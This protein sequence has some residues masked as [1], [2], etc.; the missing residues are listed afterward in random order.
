MQF[1]KAQRQQAKLRIGISAP[2]GFGKTKSSL[3]LA[4]GLCE[5]WEKIAVIDTEN[6]SADL[7]SHLGPYNVVSLDEPFS[8]EAFIKAI[9]LCEGEGMEVIIVDS[10]SA[11]WS[12]TGGCL[13]IKDAMGGAYQDWKHVTPRH[14]ALMAKIRR[15]TAHII[16][17]TR[18]KADYV[19]QLNDKGK[20]AP[21]KLG[22]KEDQRENYEYELDVNFVIEDELHQ[23]TA[24][25]DRTEL[26]DAKVP[27]V[28]TSDTGRELR[29]WAET[30]LPV[31]QIALQEIATAPAL[32]PLL[33]KYAQLVDDTEFQAACKVRQAELT[34][35]KAAQATAEAEQA[36]AEAEAVAPAPAAKP[37]PVAEQ[38]AEAEPA[39][40]PATTW[41]QLVALGND[42]AITRAEKTK[43]ITLLREPTPEEINRNAAVL[44]RLISQRNRHGVTTAANA[45]APTK[46]ERP[47]D[48]PLAKAVVLDVLKA[49]ESLTE[50]R[51]AWDGEAK[52]W[53]LDI[54][55]LAAKEE[56]KHYLT[57]DRQAA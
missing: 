16:T 12:G 10:I 23:C 40:A 51:E 25:K 41:E 38:P 42:A 30:G 29:K 43:Y 7:Y 15:S 14:N 47:A 50:L 6:Y 19:V 44:R 49:A 17:T 34:K 13:E 3:L 8:P 57:H 35:Q 18:R 52:G 5:N 28:I 48:E 37:A 24:S 54:D 32:K 20:H 22:L 33:A 9:E 46:A 4:F 45:P 26:Y 56:R 39:P 21:K 55:V 1:R 36:A 53:H 27:F 2:S 31:L 11:E